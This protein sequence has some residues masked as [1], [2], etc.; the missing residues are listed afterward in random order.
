MGHI[1]ILGISGSL[2][3]ASYNT[4]TLHAAQSLLP[5]DMTM[6][7]Y[8][9]DDLPLYNNDVEKQGFPQS[10]QRFHQRITAAN[11]I[12]FATPEYNYSIPGVLKNAIDWASRPPHE[13]PLQDKPA[14]IMGATPGGYGTVRA[15]LHLR[16]ILLHEDMPTVTKTKVLIT[17]A[18]D[19]FDDDLNLIDADSRGFIRDLLVELRDLVA[20]HRGEHTAI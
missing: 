13:S 15:Q 20:L 11:A 3:N 9:P 19:R 12:L 5:D 16:D 17:F 1:H 4:A 14:A 8:V 2:R 18:G 6:D 7:I 10:V